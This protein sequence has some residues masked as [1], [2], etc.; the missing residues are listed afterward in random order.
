MPLDTTVS[1]KPLLSQGGVWGGC[2]TRSL[3]R[4][5][6]QGNWLLRSPADCSVTPFQEAPWARLQSFAQST[7][8]KRKFC[9]SQRLYCAST[10]TLENNKT[11]DLSIEGFAL[12]FVGMT[13]FEPATTR[14]PDVYSN[15]AELHPEVHSRENL[16]FGTANIEFFFHSAKPFG[17]F[18]QKIL[19]TH[20]STGGNPLKKYPSSLRSK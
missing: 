6:L 15:R 4:E 10:Y 2:K 5:R 13:G 12:N 8:R 9:C 20:G 16:S 19:Q 7:I 14:P 1:I 11:S 18:L 3:Q 17:F